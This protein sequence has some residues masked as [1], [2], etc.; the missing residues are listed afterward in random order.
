M[1]CK[2]GE[3]SILSCNKQRIEENKD[4]IRQ[5]GLIIGGLEKYRDEIKVLANLIS[6]SLPGLFGFIGVDIFFRETRSP[7]L[8]RE[9]LH[10]LDR[11]AQRSCT[12]RAPAAR[13]AWVHSTIS[14]MSPSG[15]A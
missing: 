8:L 3:F 10:L 1:V 7:E 2:K 14:G 15:L 12:R 13:D 5:V 4:S 6:K 11:V 9:H